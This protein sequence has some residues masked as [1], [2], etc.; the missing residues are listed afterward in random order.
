MTF[1]TEEIPAT[2]PC[3]QGERA[4]E[5]RTRWRKEL[6]ESTHI[7]VPGEWALERA[8]SGLFLTACAN[9]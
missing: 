5:S 8:E 6:K 1:R 4:A 9:S 2:E 3:L 7:D